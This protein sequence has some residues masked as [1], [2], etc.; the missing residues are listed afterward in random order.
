MQVVSARWEPLC[1][2]MV[3]RCNCAGLGRA[4]ATALAYM[5]WCRGFALQD[6]IHTLKTNRACNPRIVAIRQ[7]LQRGQHFARGCCCDLLRETLLN[8]C[9]GAS[10]RSCRPELREESMEWG[11]CLPVQATTDLLVDGRG[12]TPVC[13][14]VRR[15]FLATKLQV[16]KHSMLANVW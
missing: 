10:M 16:R 15:P 2:D 14:A 9:P 3:C 6:A 11:G 13:I 1:R 7:V 8:A 4:P 12:L 5:Y